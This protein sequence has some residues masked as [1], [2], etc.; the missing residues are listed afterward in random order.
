M[1]ENQLEL[2]RRSYLTAGATAGVLGLAGFGGSAAGGGTEANGADEPIADDHRANGRA[3]IDPESDFVTFV[4][5]FTAGSDDQQRLVDLLTEFIEDTASQA[6]GF[7]SSSIHRS[8][9]G[10]RVLNY[11][12]WESVEAVETLVT[13][14]DDAAAFFGETVPRIADFEFHPYEVA[15]VVEAEDEE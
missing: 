3:V 4:N 11:A 2:N 10:V 12:Q 14:N 8:L 9:D 6:P 7:L 1:R 5:V 15:A 13:E